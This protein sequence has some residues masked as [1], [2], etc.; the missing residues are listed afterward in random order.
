[1]F[2]P[3]N[4]K[5]V[6][7]T[8]GAGF[9]GS[10]LVD[11]LIAEGKQVTVFDNL[12]SGKKDFLTRNMHKKNFHLSIGDLL[13]PQRI[14]NALNNET[15]IVFHLAA[16]PDIA[17]G[18]TDP[19]LD[20][21][22]TIVATFNLL[23]VMRKKQIKK[24]V[25]FSGSGV[26]G[27]VGKTFTPEDFGPLLPVSMYGASKLS[28]EGLI[29]AFSH[30]YVMQ[31]WIFR[32]ANII[33]NRATHGVVFDFI[34]KLKA[35][36]NKL[37]ILGDGQQSKSYLYISDVLDAVLL[38][39]ASEKDEINIFNIAS[40]TFISVNE[41]ADIVIKK[42]HLHNVIIKH[43]KGNIGW[44]G[45]VPIVRIENKKLETLGWTPRYS[46][47]LAVEKTIEELLGNEK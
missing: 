29:A 12:S 6:F 46:S 37:L 25:Y 33:G 23:Q 34:N 38:G 9:I 10:H 44:P 22:Q 45:D 19:T 11:I 4:I 41:I 8:G 42:M 27:D 28:A 24:L 47:R 31:S 5:N 13:K 16:N 39:L 32:P 35:D 1:M 26:Y 21:N 18:I 3:K 40:K 20:F 15:D 17:K 43:T 7:I 30:L 36:K 2:L 14:E